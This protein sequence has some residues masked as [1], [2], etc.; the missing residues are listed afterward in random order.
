VFT[1]WDHRSLHPYLACQRTAGGT[2]NIDGFLQPDGVTT[3]AFTFAAPQESSVPQLSSSSSL[4]SS[5]A[6]LIGT[7]RVQVFSAT[8]REVLKVPAPPPPRTSSLAA[9]ASAFAG[10]TA[11][12]KPSTIESDGTKF[13]KTALGTTVGPMIAG[14]A[15][16]AAK[17]GSASSAASAPAFASIPASTRPVIETKWE[18]KHLLGAV[19]FRYSTFAGLVLSRIVKL[20]H[21]SDAYMIPMDEL[22]TH[23]VKIVA[24]IIK[25]SGGKYDPR[26][27]F[28]QHECVSHLGSDCILCN[29][30]FSILQ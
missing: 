29:R 12:Q 18:S 24:G 15:L 3:Y 8:S 10:F 1:H 22:S 7:I 13:W 17:S 11:L 19:T 21:P 4:A 27:S 2:R 28:I 30:L 5:V 25:K 23:A 9:S 6:D 26:F 16:D 14:P 20:E